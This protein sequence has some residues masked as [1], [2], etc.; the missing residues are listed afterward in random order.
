LDDRIKQ[1]RKLSMME[2]HKKQQDAVP[3]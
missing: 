3:L 1:R 2:P